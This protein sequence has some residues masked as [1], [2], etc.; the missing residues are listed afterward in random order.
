MFL[1]SFCELLI[2]IAV[3]SFWAGA[4]SLVPTVI[5]VIVPL[6]S[7]EPEFAFVT[8]TIETATSH[9]AENDESISMCV[10]HVNP[11]AKKTRFL[12]KISIT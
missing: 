11:Q 7:F 12:I 8:I 3:G 5:L 9:A 10:L 2:N 6:S 1:K 4:F